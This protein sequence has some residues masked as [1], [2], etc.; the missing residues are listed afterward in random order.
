MRCFFAF[1]VWFF[2]FCPSV[3]VHSTSSST[4]ARSLSPTRTRDSVEQ[5]GLSG[6]WPVLN[7]ISQVCPPLPSS[8]HPC[9]FNRTYRHIKGISLQGPPHQRESV[10]GSQGKQVGA[11]RGPW[12]PRICSHSAR[13]W[14]P[15]MLGPRQAEWTL[16]A[17]TGGGD[18]GRSEPDINN[19]TK[20]NTRSMVR[21][22]YI[23]TERWRPDFVI[24]AA[25]FEYFFLCCHYLIR[26][27]W[28]SRWM[29]VGV[30]VLALHADCEGRCH[31]CVL[32]LVFCLFGLITGS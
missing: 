12:R 23:S 27:D 28:T 7:W 8:P 3:A 26:A 19:E 21:Y 6:S 22:F 17:V 11:S 1:L 2:A 24:S 32:W 9:R 25:P 5:A 20:I 16:C 18:G 4:A 30:G 10:D 29:G 31:L 13:R 14:P 15:F